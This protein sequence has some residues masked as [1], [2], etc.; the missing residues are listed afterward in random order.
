MRAMQCELC[1]GT[2][3]VK[4]DDFFVCQSCGMKYTP[5]NAKKMMIDGVVNIQGTVK[6]DNTKLID[7]YLSISRNA[8]DSGNSK[9]AEEYANKVLEIDPT[10][11]KALYLKGVAAGWQTSGMN[12]RIPE[13]V[14]CFALAIENCADEQKLEDL[15]ETVAND[16]S[17]LTLAMMRLRCE[18]YKKLPSEENAISLF[19]EAKNSLDLVLKLIASCGFKPKEFRGEAATMMNNAA[20]DA[21][22]GVIWKDYTNGKPLILTNKFGVSKYKLAQPNDVSRYAT[23]SKY[24]FD[25]L[26][27]RT[28]A[29][30]KIIEAAMSSNLSRYHRS[31]GLVPAISKRRYRE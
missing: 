11:Y 27:A 15:K 31:P 23:S 14:D 2:D 25:K 5:E 21:F 30:I 22:D 10:N 12:N 3:I 7:N 16:V 6:L 9:E 18:I 20:V 28:D 8:Y 1:G 17:K 4:E 24:D 29:C 13:A 26:L 19:A